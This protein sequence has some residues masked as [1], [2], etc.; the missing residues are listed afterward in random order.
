MSDNK[1]PS[2]DI[3]FYEGWKRTAELNDE[4]VSPFSTSAD[5]NFDEVWAGVST[6]IEFG[7]AATGETH[8]IFPSPF[9]ASAFGYAVIRNTSIF[10]EP[11]GIFS[12]GVVTSPQVRHA[13]RVLTLT[14]FDSLDMSR[15]PTIK[16]Y[17]QEVS[18]KGWDSSSIDRQYIYNLTQYRTMR[19]YD[20][21]SYGKPY[22]QGGVKYLGA[23]GFDSLKHG[24]T[25]ALNTTANRELKPAGINSLSIPIHNVSPRIV[26]PSGI[27]KSNV[28]VPDIRI[29]VIAPAG[30][31]HS[32]YGKTTVWYHT[33]PI[34]PAGLLAFD[35]GYPVVFDPTQEVQTPSLITSAIFGDTSI[36]NTSVFILPIGIDDSVV[37]PWAILTNSNRYIPLAGINSQAFGTTYV[38]N[39]TPSIFVNGIPQIGA[40]VPA[41]D[42]RVRSIGPSGFDRLLFGNPVLTK[43]PEL[44]PRSFASSTVST[45]AF[46]SHVIRTLRLNGLDHSAIAKP[47]LWFRYRYVTPTSWQSSKFGSANLTHGVRELIAKGFTKEAYGYHWVSPGTR[48]VEPLGINKINPSSHMVGGSREVKP[49]GYVATLFGERVIPET[50]QVQAQGFSE[51]WGLT[52]IR[53]NTRYLGA[54]GFITVGIQP[55]DRWGGNVKVYNLRQYIIQNYDSA[56]GLTPPTWPAWTA[57]ENRNKQLRASGFYSLKFG[58]SKIDNGAAVLL[59]SGIEPPVSTRYDVSMIAH[60]VRYVRPEGFEPPII[61]SWLVLNNDARVVGVPGFVDTRSGLASAVNTR[62]Y[63]SGVGRF[64]SSEYGLPMISHAIRYISLEPRYAIMPPQ[65]NLPIIDTWTKYATF[66]GFEAAKYGLPSLNITFNIIAPKWVHRNN[67]GEGYIKNLTPEVG[68]YGHDSSLFGHASTRTQWR[69]V[70]AIGDTLSL[71]GLSRISDTKQVIGIRGWQDSVYSQKHTVVR[72]GAPP[73]SQQIISLDGGYDYEKNQPIPGNG[74]YFD[75]NRLGARIPKPGINQNV[76]YPVSFEPSLFGVS[77]VHSNNIQITAGIAI[78][79]ISSDHVVYNKTIYITLN[80]EDAIKSKVELG[81]PRMSPWT[82]YAVMEAPQ[83]AQANYDYRGQL[84]YVNSNYG[85]QAPGF[86]VGTPRVDST[87]RTV[88]PLSFDAARYTGP[89]LFLTKKVISP[90]SFGATKVGQPSIPFTDQ[91]LQVYHADEKPIT[92]YGMAKISIID[93]QDK[94]LSVTGFLSMKIDGPNIDLLHRVLGA[95]GR[96]SL[97]MGSKLS[98]DKPYMWQGLRVGAH[99]PTIVGGGDLSA[100]GSSMI[101]LLIRDIA[102]EGFNAFTSEYDTSNFG[103]RMTVSRGKVAP[104]ETRRVTAEGFISSNSNT[105]T[106]VRFGQYFIRPDGN[107]DQFRKGGYHA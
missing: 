48:L 101:S 21:S 99:V 26:Y 85:R 3:D 4:S 36:K 24:V 61:S 2:S 13:Y 97:A 49:Q 40:G 33:R 6:T 32:E 68:I 28:G 5:I 78:H 31:T 66:R 20:A 11:R 104:P 60:G 88:K 15:K 22:I 14:G 44:A 9:D 23:I 30:I 96:D 82:I 75:E 81:K 83:Q 37:T 90:K 95:K 38:R 92:E 56:S 55:A 74:I 73:Y 65:I 45:T 87:I 18:T 16:N 54:I 42:Y 35:S 1:N 52:A 64:E 67:I 76:I 27:Y 63:Y 84:H 50:K 62:R 8:T 103:G 86:K 89:S 7:E 17:N 107:S 91:M 58:Y 57:V 19:G 69:E 71:F 72:T 79:N 80:E 46:I 29:P 102:L 106:D 25:I 51:Q 94:T 41:I 59:P 98:N 34:A 10:V 43:S 100:F 77:K 105:V 12:A 93:N 39:K 70:K 47:T 53:L